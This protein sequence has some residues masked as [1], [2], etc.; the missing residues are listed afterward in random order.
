MTVASLWKA[1]DRGGSGQP[2]GTQTLVASI[3]ATQT[4]T[5]PRRPPILAVDL[6]IWICE[7]LTA[8]G[9]KDQHANPAL[10]LV[11]TRTMKL[12]LLGVRLVFVAEG[13]QRTDTGTTRKRRSG[14]PFWNAVRD[15][16]AMLELLGIPVVRA[17]C[18]G[19]ALC[20]LL[21]QRGLVDGVISN[22]GDCL[23][24]GAK[25]VYTKYSNENLDQGRVM[26]YTSDS[27][28][29]VVDASDDK[30][31]AGS[32]VGTIALGRNDL[33][34]FAILT[35]S[36]VAGGGLPKVGHY[37]AIRF[38]RKCHCD[39]PLSKETASIDE[40][41]SWSRA[42]KVV[43]CKPIAD[44]TPA[45]KAEKCCSRC[46]HGGSKRSHL[47]HG[48]VTCGTE[49]GEPCYQTT[50]EDRFRKSLRAK[51]LSLQDAFDPS[52]TIE[53]YMRPNDNQ[54]PVLF[55]NGPKTFFAPRLY[56]IL[57]SKL[58]VKGRSFE[59]SRQFVRQTVL[60]TLSR[61]TLHRTSRC[62]GPAL[63]SID[64]EAPIPTKINR[65]VTQNQTPCYEVKWIV[66]ATV[67]NEEGEGVDGFEYV[68]VEEKHVVEQRFP[69]LVTAFQDVEKERAK[70]GDEMQRQ[71]REFLE[72]FLSN[73]LEKEERGKNRGKRRRQVTRKR[74]DFF[75]DLEIPAGRK[76]KK[77]SK[78]PERSGGDDVGMLL[79]FATHRPIQF[80][81]AN[82]RARDEAS[83]I[84]RVFSPC[85][86]MDLP[87]PTSSIQTPVDDD[88]LV[89]HMG[90]VEVEI[91]PIESNRGA[92]PPRNIFVHQRSSPL[93][94]KLL[95]P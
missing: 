42:A 7:A 17:K 68:T 35:G 22:D 94:R 88:R 19:E 91:T 85:C 59:G 27:L 23:P 41:R 45:T 52:Q 66:K 71:R 33:I 36:D 11:Y 95:E 50:K 26:R 18:E 73:K 2:V 37:K 16:Q 8:F 38:I 82:T 58:I 43:V 92:F 79:R 56:D 48:C 62:A 29:A 54:I 31:I 90:A 24:F 63:Q 9:L 13:K 57:K 51:A 80:S 53:I 39:H 32:E 49:P 44:D 77:R 55:V 40:L 4:T 93:R 76:T 69:E 75:G 70:Q 10:Y 21:N 30:D 6:S 15:C 34:A 72:K 12:L 78:R 28:N 64:R 47:K 1:V 25:V 46:G 61:V 3:T 5:Q 89:C 60:R 74:D 14:T 20:A 65:S 84:A 86:V 81:P 87:A 83:L 67:T